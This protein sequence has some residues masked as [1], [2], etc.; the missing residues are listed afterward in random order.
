MPLPINPDDLNVHYT[1]I[2]HQIKEYGMKLKLPMEV[3]CRYDEIEC[4]SIVEAFYNGLDVIS[5][6]E[7]YPV[8]ITGHYSVPDRPIDYVRK[9]L[10]DIFASIDFKSVTFYEALAPYWKELLNAQMRQVPVTLCKVIQTPVI[11]RYV[12]AREFET[13]ELDEPY[14]IKRRQQGNE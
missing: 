5:K 11:V 8:E 9:G 12:Y 7:D 1:R 4:V 14:T 13:K 10:R 6:P 3:L 2:Q